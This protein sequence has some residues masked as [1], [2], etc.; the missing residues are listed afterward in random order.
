M[1]ASTACAHAKEAS[2]HALAGARQR[3]RR[4]HGGQLA[5]RAYLSSGSLTADLL[6][7]P[8]LANAA[9]FQ[10]VS[11]NA[12]SWSRPASFAYQRSPDAAPSP[13]PGPPPA[14]VD[15]LTASQDRAVR[16]KTSGGLVIIIAGA[17]AGI[18]LLATVAL[19]YVW[20]RR[21]AKC[22]RGIPV[23]AL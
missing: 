16:A 21:G 13:A 10:N 14:Q 18:G 19:V 17:A 20:R 1:P 12:S 23:M 22:K 3:P 6:A 11:F 9:L 2:P 5:L 4:G 7:Y 8:L 15:T